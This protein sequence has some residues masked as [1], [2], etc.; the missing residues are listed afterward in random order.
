MNGYILY[1]RTTEIDLLTQALVNTGVQCF[2]GTIDG[3]EPV[4]LYDDTFR[5]EVDLAT[6]ET[7]GHVHLGRSQSSSARHVGEGGG[8][9]VRACREPAQNIEVRMTA[10]AL[11]EER[12]PQLERG[13]EEALRLLEIHGEVEVEQ[14]PFPRPVRRPGGGG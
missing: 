3:S 13:V 8:V 11:S 4:V 5:F 12:D 14:P 9:Q 1:H 10:R 6:G 7:L 2:S